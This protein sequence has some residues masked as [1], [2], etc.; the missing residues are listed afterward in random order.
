MA[1][2]NSSGTFITT[3]RGHRDNHTDNNRFFQTR[4]PLPI[5]GPPITQSSV[6]PIERNEI[7]GSRLMPDS[8]QPLIVR[9]VE[10]VV[11]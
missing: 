3:N 1:T 6:Q 9:I 10:Q 11:N 7:A 4:T 8:L 2:R 5:A